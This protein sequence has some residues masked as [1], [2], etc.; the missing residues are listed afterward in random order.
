MAMWSV[1]ITEMITNSVIKQPFVTRNTA[2]E[3]QFENI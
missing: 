2:L 1:A 3:L